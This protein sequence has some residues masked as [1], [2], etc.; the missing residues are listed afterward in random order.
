MTLISYLGN[1]YFKQNQSFSSSSCYFLIFFVGSGVSF[2]GVGI[3]WI[4]QLGTEEIIDQP[5]IIGD[6]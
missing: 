4:L 1:D 6:K 3:F 2:I 5:I